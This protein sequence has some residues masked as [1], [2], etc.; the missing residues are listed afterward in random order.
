MSK[1]NI[2]KDADLGTRIYNKDHDIFYIKTKKGWQRDDN[3][4]SQLSRGWKRSQEDPSINFGEGAP[5]IGSDGSYS[6]TDKDLLSLI[7]VILN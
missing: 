2:L 1:Q 4:L 5:T 3:F 6:T 7:K